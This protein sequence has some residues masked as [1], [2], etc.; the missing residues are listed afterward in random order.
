MVSAGGTVHSQ[1]LRG[2]P[3]AAWNEVTSQVLPESSD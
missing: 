2:N 3:E 1:G